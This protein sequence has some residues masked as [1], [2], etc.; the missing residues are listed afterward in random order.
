ARRPQV[1][2]A[3]AAGLAVAVIGLAAWNLALSSNSDS[4]TVTTTQQGSMTLKVSYFHDQQ[5]AVMDVTMPALPANQTY[6]AWMIDASGKPVSMGLMSNQ[7]SFAFHTDLS[8]AKAIAISVEPQGGSP[9]PTT[10]P[11]LVQEL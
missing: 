2:Y 4:V 5:V 1:G 3:L 10:T 9:Q 8:D 7:G 6:Q 11:V